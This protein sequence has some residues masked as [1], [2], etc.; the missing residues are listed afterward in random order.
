MIIFKWVLHIICTCVWWHHCVHCFILFL[1]LCGSGRGRR[2]SSEAPAGEQQCWGS[3]G[4]Q[5]Q[6]QRLPSVYFLLIGSLLGAE[7]G[8]RGGINAHQHFRHWNPRL[9]PHRPGSGKRP[10]LSRQRVPRGEENGRF[11]IIILI[12]VIIL[13]P[14]WSIRPNGWTSTADS[15]KRGGGRGGGRGGWAEGSARAGGGAR[16][17]GSALHFLL[18]RRLCAFTLQPA[19][20]CRGAELLAPGGGVRRMWPR[21]HAGYSGDAVAHSW[22]HYRCGCQTFE[23]ERRDT[24]LSFVT[25]LSRRSF[26]AFHVFFVHHAVQ[27]CLFTSNWSPTF[28]YFPALWPRSSPVSCCI[29][30]F[31]FRFQKTEL[32]INWTERKT[33]WSV[34]LSKGSFFF[35]KPWF[36][37]FLCFEV[38]CFQGCSETGKGLQRFS[39]VSA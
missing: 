5:R 23:R 25:L 3:A 27:F 38:V 19:G 30:K 15:W 37:W 4:R 9:L 13:L 17:R 20:F 29:T 10:A 8:A 31:C 34:F 22:G 6:R 18:V 28:F 7:G 33:N 36:C 26:F 39:P 14:S 24:P 12:F 2:H 32:R 11:F 16:A 1:C 35:F 21:P